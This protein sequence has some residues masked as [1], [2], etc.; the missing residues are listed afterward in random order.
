MRGCRRSTSEG[1]G[2]VN[3]KRFEGLVERALEHVPETFREAMGNVAI[4]I[5]EWPSRELM[6]EMYG[7]P[8]TYVYGLFTGS[9]L[10]RYHAK[11]A[12]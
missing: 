1:I 7:D 12:A 11:R 9:V 8:D 6:A 4:V 2:Q 10:H 3:R 5:D